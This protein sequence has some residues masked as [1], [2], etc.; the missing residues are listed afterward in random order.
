MLQNIIINYIYDNPP[1]G[2]SGIALNI[3]S[4]YFEDCEGDCYCTSDCVITWY[5]DDDGDDYHS[6]TLQSNEQPGNNWKITTLGEDCDD[7]NNKVHAAGPIDLPDRMIF[8]SSREPGMEENG[9]E[10]RDYHSGDL[11]KEQVFAEIE[12]L[13]GFWNKWRAKNK[14]EDICEMTNEELFQEMEDAASLT[15]DFQLLFGEGFGDYTFYENFSSNIEMINRFR[16]NTRG[17]NV[18]SGTTHSMLLNDT[19]FQSYISSLLSQIQIEL[20]NVNSVDE[21]S[22]LTISGISSPVF[23]VG[24]NRF[25]WNSSWSMKLKLS[26][27]TINC[28]EVSGELVIDAYDQFG[29]DT[30]DMFSSPFSSRARKLNGFWAWFHL[31]RVIGIKPFINQFSNS[32]NI[33]ATIE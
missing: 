4:V 8:E 5:L 12:N 31:Q 33:N 21:I 15:L 19:G 32:F 29:L 20:A 30:M 7:D 3:D 16:Q 22:Q 27:L 6:Q 2:G 14:Y 10:A 26:N 1:I 17:I 11:I 23:G 24:G 28:A 25:N 9:T 18:V 13:D